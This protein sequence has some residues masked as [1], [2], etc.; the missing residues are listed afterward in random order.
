MS[1]D[2]VAQEVFHTTYG[3]N[4]GVLCQVHGV[5][6]PHT[7]Q[8]DKLHAHLFLGAGVATHNRLLLLGTL[9]QFQVEHQLRSLQGASDAE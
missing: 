5:E 1:R 7:K 8:I 9:R 4:A 2:G 6:L 3:I